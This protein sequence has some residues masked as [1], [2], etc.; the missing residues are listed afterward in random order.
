LTVGQASS[1]VQRSPE[2]VLAVLDR[3]TAPIR[4]DRAAEIRLLGMID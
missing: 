4:R 2:S 1:K 3:A